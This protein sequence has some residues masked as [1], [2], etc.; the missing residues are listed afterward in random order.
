LTNRESSSTFV[1]HFNERSMY[2]EPSFGK[3]GAM[4]KENTY[5]NIYFFYKLTDTYSQLIRFHYKKNYIALPLPK[6]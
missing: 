5:L 3:N 4:L 1:F 6:T 2:T